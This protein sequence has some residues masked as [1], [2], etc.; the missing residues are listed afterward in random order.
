M[1][2]KY[3]GSLVETLIFREM[4]KTGVSDVT[5]KNLKKDQLEI[6]R[7]QAIEKVI[8]HNANAD[9]RSM[10]L[11]KFRKEDVV[12]DEEAVAFLASAAGRYISHQV[13]D[14]ALQIIQ[15]EDG[16]SLA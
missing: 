12:I 2:D 14:S 9:Y 13:Y 15:T 6:A 8:L 3:Y 5:E 4:Q 10:I 16:P 11:S 1:F 7:A